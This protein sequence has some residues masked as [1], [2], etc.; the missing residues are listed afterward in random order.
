MKGKNI[1]VFGSTGQVGKNLIR[2]LTKNNHRVTAVTR[3]LHKKGYI[4][5]TSGNAG[6]IDVVESN[7][8]N[9][10]NLNNLIK[11]KDICINLVGILFE[12]KNNTF[13]NIHVNFPSIVSKICEE[14]NLNQLIHISALGIEDA[15]D[16]SYAKSKMEG[17]KEIIKNFKKATILRPSVIFSQGD[18]FSCNLMTLIGRLPF[19]PVY[20]NGRTKFSPIHCSDLTEIILKIIDDKIYSEII[21]CTGPEII[22]FK[23]I[24]LILMKLIEKNRLIVPMPILAAKITA[25]LFELLP[26]PLITNDQLRL[27]KYDSILSGKY[28]SNVD[29][30]YEC[31]LKFEDEVQKYCYMWKEFGEYS[32]K[33]ID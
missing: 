8:F 27:L 26:S 2:K 19:F 29:I 24:I 16:S 18:N 22:T 6:Y 33:K 23:E 11:N 7:I 15:H 21:E 10:E 28:K 17:E 5:R 9:E 13:K 25:S 31:K 14:N 1:L 20:Y 4:L 32:K 12:K 30:N 3:N